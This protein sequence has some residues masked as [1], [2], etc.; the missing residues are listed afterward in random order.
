M[1]NIT[2]VINIIRLFFPGIDNLPSKEF[3][4]VSDEICDFLEKYKED[5]ILTNEKHIYDNNGINIIGKA[6]FFNK[7][8]IKR[9][10]K[11]QT[12]VTFIFDDKDLEIMKKMEEYFNTNNQELY[13]MQY[14]KTC[15]QKESKSLQK[16][17]LD[18]F[19]EQND[20]K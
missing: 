1:N 3:E 20:S 19:L 14:N 6:K 4:K 18:I 2:K 7:D 17:P 13:L 10:K 9:T 15:F 5:I 12:K 11:S 16:L 8:P